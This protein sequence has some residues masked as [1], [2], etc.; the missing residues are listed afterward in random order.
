METMKSEAKFFES[1][2]DAILAAIVAN[3]KL[4]NRV[5]VESDVMVVVEDVEN[6][7]CIMPRGEAEAMGEAYGLYTV[8]YFG[9][10]DY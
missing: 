5:H 2:A 9:P 1:E 6:H 3:R 4:R 7:Y 8:E 10:D